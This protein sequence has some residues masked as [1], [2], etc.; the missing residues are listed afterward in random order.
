MSHVIALCL[1]SGVLVLLVCLWSPKARSRA[2][3]EVSGALKSF[4]PREKTETLEE[5]QGGAPTGARTEK[6]RRFG[7]WIA[8]PDFQYPS[9]DQIKNFNVDEVVPIPYRPFR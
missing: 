1:S 9:I 4:G 6:E 7:E 5:K 8:D 2:L 3:L